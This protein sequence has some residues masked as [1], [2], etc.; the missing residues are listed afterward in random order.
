MLLSKVPLWGPSPVLD[1]LSVPRSQY[2]AATLFRAFARN[3]KA[4]CQVSHTSAP[5]GFNVGSFWTELRSKKRPTFWTD[6]FYLQT[7]SLNELLKPQRV[8][9]Y[10]GRWARGLRERS[11]QIRSLRRPLISSSFCWRS[12]RPWLSWSNCCFLSSRVRWS[13]ACRESFSWLLCDRRLFWSRKACFSW[14]ACWRAARNCP[15]CCSCWLCKNTPKEWKTPC[16][17]RGKSG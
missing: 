12:L 15:I 13:S 16:L 5:N 11:R 10:Q 1:V 8:N 2:T 6:H 14:L 4:P 17:E 7:F 3:Q 9:A